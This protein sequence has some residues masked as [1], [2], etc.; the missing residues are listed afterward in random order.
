MID[1]TDAIDRVGSH[2]SHD[3][4]VGNVSATIA[5]RGRTF[6]RVAL[7]GGSHGGDVAAAAWP[8]SGRARDTSPHAPRQPANRWR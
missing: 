5:A 3:S 1:P 7:A 2:E 6:A 4:T 8:R